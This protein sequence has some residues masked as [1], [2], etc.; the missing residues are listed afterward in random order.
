MADL[1]QSELTYKIIGC[2][3]RVHGEVG[4]GLREKTYER[5][6]CV[7]FRHAGLNFAQQAPCPVYYRGEVVDEYI[8]DLD[9]ESSVLVDAKT[10]DRITD[11]E[12][13]QML[14]YLRITQ[15]SIGLII[16]FKHESLEWE[17]I[18]L[19]PASNDNQR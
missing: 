17:R 16:N 18:V 7:E 1:I 13:G 9:I 4:R 5:A 6:L 2:A 8:P 10:I 19:E 14:N 15:R 3:M 12:R 11:A